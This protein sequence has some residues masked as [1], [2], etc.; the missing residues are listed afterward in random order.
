MWWQ[1]D[2]DWAISMDELAALG[3]EWAN[4]NPGQY[5]SI[6]ESIQSTHLATLIYTSGTTGRSKGVELTHDCWLFEAESLSRLG[7]M[8]PADKQFLWLPMAHSFGKVLE[9]IVIQLGIP[10]AIDGRIDR[11]VENLGVVRPTF[12]AAVPRIFEKVYNKVVT[13]AR[14]GGRLKW[15]I[16]QWSLATGRQVS[17][18]RQQGDE[19]RGLLALR[20]A[21]AD[22]L[23]FSKLKA[24]FGGQM[25]FF[26]SG[27]APLSREIAEFF[28]AAD[29]LILEGYGL[30]ES[31]AAS[32]VNRPDRYRFGSVGPAIPGVEVKISPEDGEILLAGRGIMRGYHNLQEVTAETLTEDG[33]LRTGDIGSIDADGFLKITDRKKALIKTSGGKYVAP[34]EL[35][36]KLKLQ[37]SLIS[38]VV[39]HG[40]RRNFCSALL[41]LDEDALK[42]WASD[43]EKDSMSYEQLTRAPEI[44]E[45]IQKAVNAM[46]EGLPSYSTIKKFALLPSDFTVESGELT[47]SMK[48]KRKAVEKKYMDILDTFYGGALEQL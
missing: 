31:S 48:V 34:Q 2:D 1:S 41:T 39:V 40:D 7:F 29:I 14:E 37:S 22:A 15:R 28:H 20:Y 19:P 16:F 8:T 42:K 33:W 38:Q 35:E 43:H 10:T 46:N 27:S 30:T 13:G 21:I 25:R 26:I 45:L 24:T 12:V 9:A 32:F 5:Q 4:Q 23:V 47:P 18:L 11:I 44:T 36:N 6:I 17:Q 3:K